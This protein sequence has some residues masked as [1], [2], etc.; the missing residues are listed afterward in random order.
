VMEMVDGNKEVSQR[1]GS[2][3]VLRSALS[4]KEGRVCHV[5]DCTGRGWC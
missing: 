3:D 4:E 5:G 1:F 2:Q